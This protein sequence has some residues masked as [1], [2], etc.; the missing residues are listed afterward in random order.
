MGVGTI[1]AWGA[2]M[3]YGDTTSGNMNYI[4]MQDTLRVDVE[5]DNALF[6]GL[7]YNSD[8]SSNFVNESLITKRYADNLV[9][10]RSWKAP[11]VVA[12]D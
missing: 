4:K 1:R 12:V 6:E 10:G 3:R 11:V 7:V 8:I 5:S 9:N 2:F